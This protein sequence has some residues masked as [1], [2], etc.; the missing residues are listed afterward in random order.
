MINAVVYRHFNKDGELLYIGNTKNFYERSESH[1]RNCLWFKEIHTITLEHH[2]SKHEASYAEYKAIKNENSLYN[3]KFTITTYVATKLRG[4][5]I[6]EDEIVNFIEMHRK[7]DGE[8][9]IYKK[10]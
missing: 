7:D 10:S 6:T 2:N 3:K 9:D 5:G 4:L 8:I 1:A